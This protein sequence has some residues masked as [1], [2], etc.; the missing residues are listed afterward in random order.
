MAAVASFVRGGLYWGTWGLETYFKG[1]GIYVPFHVR[2]GHNS[3][4]LA[5]ARQLAPSH[6]DGEIHGLG[7]M[8]S[9]EIDSALNAGSFAEPWNAA[10]NSVASIFD[11]DNP[12]LETRYFTLPLQEHWND[13]FFFTLNST[14]ANGPPDLA[15]QAAVD[16]ALW[17]R[18]HTK[19]LCV[20]AV[21]GRLVGYSSKSKSYRIYSPVT[22]QIV[23]SRNV[24][25]IETASQLLSPS[26]GESLVQVSWNE[27]VSNNNSHNYAT[28]DFLH[29]HCNYIP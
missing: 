14:G 16:A 25:F 6:G 29:D 28:D 7:G 4:P 11:M 12:R 17:H 5:H 2:G 18:R 24:V 13:L 20:R 27:G 15:M 10:R 22:R 3:L 23:E 21:E 1:L 26:T 19:K 8:A 9:A